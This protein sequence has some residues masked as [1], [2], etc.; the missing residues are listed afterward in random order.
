M[1]INIFINW[2]I[3]LKDIVFFLMFD[4]YFIGIVWSSLSI[5]SWKPCRKVNNKNR[6]L[7]RFTHFYDPDTQ[8]SN[9]LAWNEPIKAGDSYYVT[10][11]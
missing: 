11:R 8:D 6:V 9:E 7:G 3:F 10:G 2:S 5:S 1:E 4:T